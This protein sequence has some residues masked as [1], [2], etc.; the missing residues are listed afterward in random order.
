MSKRGSVESA[1]LA[2]VLVVALI[3]LYVGLQP[4]E[5]YSEGFL[6]VG[7]AST[8]TG[9]FALPAAKEYGGA[10]R[11][12]AAPGTRAFP[13]GRALETDI[14]TCYSCSCLEDGLTASDKASA[15]K[16]CRDNC[17]GT[18]VSQTAGACR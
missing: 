9:H 18:I 13:A 2:S 4:D 16:V 5:A 12:I 15:E 14:Q 3:G 11:G 8:A 7:S 6:T 1:V 10:V 17:A